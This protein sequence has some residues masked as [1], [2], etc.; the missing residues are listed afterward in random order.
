[1]HRTTILSTLGARLDG[2]DRR[3]PLSPGAMPM[4]RRQAL[5]GSDRESTD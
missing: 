2:L 5:H 4:T 3:G 1:M